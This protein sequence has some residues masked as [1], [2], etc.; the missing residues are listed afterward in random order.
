ME[1]QTYNVVNKIN[2]ALLHG[3]TE[4]EV[5]SSSKVIKILQVIKS[6]GL[7][8]IN[9]EKHVLKI[10]INKSKTK[11]T[12]LIRKIRLLSTPGRA[13]PVR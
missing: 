9:P 1:Y 11:G 3:K 6:E 13:V 8:E 7:V 12:P 5:K 4:I 10:S 2:I